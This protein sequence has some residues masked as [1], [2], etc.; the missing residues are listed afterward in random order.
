[1]KLCWNCQS[2]MPLKARFCPSCGAKQ[3]DIKEAPLE[4][5][6]FD[7]NEP[8]SKQFTEQFFLA[9]KRRIQ[10]EHHGQ[11]FQ[12]FSERVY[13]S[14]FRDTIARRADELQDTIDLKKEKGQANYRQINQAAELMLEDILDF[15]I[16]RYCPDLTDIDLP[17]TILKH[18][19]SNG[20]K[21]NLQTLIQDYL[22]LDNERERVY[23]DFL[24][25][26][27][28]P[29]KNAGKAFLH[30]AKDEKIFF[31]CDSSPTGNGKEGFAMTDRSLYWRAPFQKGKSV[32][33]QSIQVLKQEKDWIIINNHFF[34]I[35]PTLNLK[36]LKL[37]KK[38]QVWGY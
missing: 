25:M 7:I 15:F 6:L 31:I 29:L 16:I 33:Y 2:T 8:I 19:Y 17:E 32:N 13:E 38:I 9:L 21:S 34:N 22:D 27:V 23:S 20:R 14:G 11:H 5:I 36:L 37:L 18:Q 28:E 1:M 24:N 4:K 35:N 26:P 12:A 3:I 30:P 10:T